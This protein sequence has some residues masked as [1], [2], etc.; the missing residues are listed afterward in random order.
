MEMRKKLL[1]SDGFTLVEMMVVGAI[2][3]VL[4]LAFS[5]YMFQQ[6][7]QNKQ[8]EAKHGALRKGWPA[9]QTWAANSG[10]SRRSLWVL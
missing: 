10:G 9:Q 6:A 3:S 4:M 5:A 1:S 7:K 8:Q 2:L